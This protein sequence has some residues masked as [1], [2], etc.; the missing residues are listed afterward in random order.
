M[1][2][3]KSASR[4]VELPGL[5]GRR[6]D[7]EL[8]GSVRSEARDRVGERVARGDEL[9]R[10]FE[11]R[12]VLAEI[13]LENKRTDDVLYG[14]QAR[15]PVVGF[16]QDRNLKCAESEH[17][18]GH[19]G[20]Q[21]RRHDLVGSG[22]TEQAHQLEHG[23]FQGLAE[24]DGWPGEGEPETQ[25]SAHLF[26]QDSKVEVSIEW[27]AA[28]GWIRVAV[29]ADAVGQI[30][31]IGG[32]KETVQIQRDVDHLHVRIRGEACVEQVEVI[33]RVGFE[34]IAQRVAEDPELLGHEPSG[35]LLRPP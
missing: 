22:L 2:A 29:E 25:R 8:E 11:R 28:R 32:R 30:D 26:A 3:P 17:A 5:H 1:S 6:I 4:R 20:A 35:R 21:A 16:D 34:R 10:Q 9:L 13:A 7:L 19:P 15:G 33:R 24:R 23:G 14:A 12:E 31:R 27:G 18:L